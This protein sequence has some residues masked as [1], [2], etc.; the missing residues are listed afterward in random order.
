MQA[1]AAQ[2]PS[3]PGH[4]LA[5]H[6]SA[7][8][9]P[10]TD[11]PTPPATPPA[12]RGD[13]SSPDLALDPLAVGALVVDLPD[14]PLPS[15]AE[16]APEVRFLALE[17]GPERGVPGLWL[18]DRGRAAGLFDL[19]SDLDWLT[20]GGVGRMWLPRGV[21]R[22]EACTFLPELPGPSGAP[23][24]LDRQGADLVCALPALDADLVARLPEGASWSL[25]LLGLDS[26][27]HLRL[28]AEDASPGRLRFARG[29]L[30][31][32]AWPGE[33]VAWSLELSADGR[34]IW[35]HRGRLR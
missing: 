6:S 21:A 30:V 31:L 16:P 32:D 12:W 1:R 20:S 7:P 11:P 15:A 14:E 28:T 25:G 22:V 29:G 9:A 10:P 8:P 3:S 2:W 33:D 27:D 4:S 34:T 19:S 26:F 35:R 17:G 13:A 23:V 18:A 24:L 5:T